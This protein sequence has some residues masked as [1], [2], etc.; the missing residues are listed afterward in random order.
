MG[1][2]Q[3]VA[4]PVGLAIER[5]PVAA[6]SLGLVMVVGFVFQFRGH[7]LGWAAANTVCVLGATIFA[8]NFIAP[9]I[10]QATSVKP[11]AIHLANVRTAN[12]PVL[13]SRSLA[14]GLYFYTGQTLNVVANN[15]HPFYSSHALPVVVGNRGLETFLREHPNAIGVFTTRE[16]NEI[17]SLR[18]LAH[19]E[20]LHLFGP[21]VLVQFHGHDAKQ[22]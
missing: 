6:A 8:L 4:L 14:R 13:C 22:L 11:L 16:W 12:E 20:D 15:P 5:Y 17:R 9:R 21:K 3:A 10:E 18:G 19:E 1:F 2:A 7:W